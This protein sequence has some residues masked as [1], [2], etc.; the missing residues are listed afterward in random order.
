[1]KGYRFLIEVGT[2]TKIYSKGNKRICVR[3]GKV[4]HRYEVK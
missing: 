1:M 3:H 2:D 4:T